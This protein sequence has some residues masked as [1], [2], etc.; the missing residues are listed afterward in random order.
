MRRKGLNLIA[1]MALTIGVAFLL[2]TCA[3]APY[4]PDQ[5]IQFSH[6]IHA[7]ENVEKGENRIA[8]Q[9]CH[10]YARRSTAAGVPSVNTC[11]NCHVIVAADKPEV[12]KAL[13]YWNKKEPI[14]WIK[15]YDLP[16]FVYFSHKRHVKRGL[17]CEACH[18]KVQTMDRVRR[19]ASLE[20][21]WCVECHKRKKADLDCLVCHK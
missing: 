17:E 13:G 21:G 18:G 20:M 16:D 15:V 12:K 8:C 2:T 3:E 7:G 4:A 11:Y 9:Y 5:P 19:V 1:L 10:A 14:P 6:R